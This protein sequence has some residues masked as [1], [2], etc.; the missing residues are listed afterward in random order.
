ML[1]VVV[2]VV[3]AS[4]AWVLHLMNVSML[5]EFKRYQEKKAKNIPRGEKDGVSVAVIAGESMGV[6]SPVQ[7]LTPAYYLDF[8]IEPGCSFTQD[9]P[10]GWNSSLYVVQGKCHYYCKL[11]EFLSPLYHLVS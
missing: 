7:T 6:K 1:V 8:T 4:E 9:V 2:V 5:C 11:L 10:Q 3:E